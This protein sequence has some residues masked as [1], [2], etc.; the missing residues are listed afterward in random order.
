MNNN[1]PIYNEIK[2]LAPLLAGLMGKNPYRVPVNYFM[3]SEEGILI[4]LRH[5]EESAY[6]LPDQLRDTNPFLVPSQYFDTLAER[7]LAINKNLDDSIPQ[8][9]ANRST[10]FS[11]PADYFQKLETRIATRLNSEEDDLELELAGLNTKSAFV[12]PVGYF[13]SL[14]DR[15]ISNLNEGESSTILE[16]IGKNAGFLTPANYFEELPELIEAKIMA[17][18]VGEQ[19]SEKNVRQLPTQSKSGSSLRRTLT[20]LAALLILVSLGYGL[21]NFSAVNSNTLASNFDIN[22]ALGSLSTDE[23]KSFVNNNIHEFDTELLAQLS[24]ND[25][26]NESLNF[27][28]IDTKELEQYLI[29]NIDESLIKEML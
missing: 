27:D 22:Q 8:L 1:S 13:D 14:S 10:G 29:Q 6:S 28:G 3:Q 11:L 20:G 2:P 9:D 15:I 21:W 7:L 18:E 16:G 26:K 17:A 23:M 19:P 12:L 25:N 4:G 24:D 5:G